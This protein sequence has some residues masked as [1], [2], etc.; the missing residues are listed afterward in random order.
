[1]VNIGADYELFAGRKNFMELH[2]YGKVY[3]KKEMQEI[4]SIPD[5]LIE[6]WGIKDIDLFNFAKEKFLELSEQKKPFHILTKTIDLHYPQCEKEPRCPNIT[7]N[8]SKN[9]LKCTDDNINDF[10]N[11][12]KQQPNYSDTLIVILPDHLYFAIMAISQK[13]LV[14]KKIENFML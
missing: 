13:V 11:F 4:M 1:M 3:G 7:N 8:N 9:I 10:I 14:I 6:G 12:L 2:G 5:F